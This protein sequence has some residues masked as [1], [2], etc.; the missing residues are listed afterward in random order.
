M[1]FSIVHNMDQEFNS[2]VLVCHIIVDTIFSSYKVHSFLDG[3]D[4]A[5]GL[6]NFNKE[7]GPAVSWIVR[8]G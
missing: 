7:M 6:S 5:A 8:G 1:G 2:A 4:F 3:K